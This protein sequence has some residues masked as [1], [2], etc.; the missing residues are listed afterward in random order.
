MAQTPAY[1]CTIT[2][3]GGSGST[4]G[5]IL[6][7]DTLY[8]VGGLG[9]NGTGTVFSIKTNGTG[10]KVL[11]SFAAFGTNSSGQ[12]TNSDGAYPRCKLLASG[13]TLYGTTTAGGYPYT[14]NPP[15]CGTVFKVNTDGSGFETIHYFNTNAT[16]GRIP[17]AGV[18]LQGNTLYGTTQSGGTSNCGTVFAVN[19]DGVGY[20][21]LHSFNYGDGASPEAG[22]VLSGSTLYGTTTSGSAYGTIF[23]LNTDGSGF[24]TLHSFANS[25]AV[26]GQTALALSRN[27]L[28]GANN[29]IYS[30]NTDGTGFTNLIQFGNSYPLG[31]GSYPSELTASDTAVYGALNQGGGIVSSQF[32]ASYGT[33]FTINTDG[34]GFRVMYDF[35]VFLG[36]LDS[37]GTPNQQPS[38][39]GY[40][41]LGA[42]AVSNNILYGTCSTNVF[43]M[44]FLRPDRPILSTPYARTRFFRISGPTSATIS[45]FRLDGNLVWGN[46]TPGATYT[47]QTTSAAPDN[48]NWV[49]YVEIPA[50]NSMN[51]NLIYSF[52]PPKG[53]TLIPA[54]SY[55]MGDTLDGLAT[56]AKIYLSGFYMETNLVTVGLWNSV[57]AWATNHGYSSFSA[58]SGLT[59]GAA[60]WWWSGGYG[61]AWCNARSQMEGLTPV[62]YPDAGFTGSPTSPSSTNGTYYANWSANGYRLPTDAEWEKAARGGL[63]GMRF[64]WG[65]LC[66]H[67]L[68]SYC[69]DTSQDYLFDLGPDGCASNSFTVGQYPPNGY[70][71]Y[72]MVSYL[73]QPCWSPSYAPSCQG[74]VFCAGNVAYS[75]AAYM[76]V[77]YRSFFGPKDGGGSR[78]FRCARNIGP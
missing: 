60:G 30:I 21:N 31:E 48:T 73:C 64:P 76:R 63:K 62:Y 69:S 45:E 11:H 14:F 25:G 55:T 6:S 56:P 71:L 57:T 10:F 41:P 34:T 12:Q 51:T 40:N 59:N 42:L 16:D 7:G 18:V 75:T 27:K 33:I 15:N 61:C 37:F 36:Y 38:S 46:A 67:T 65:N 19:T 66:D 43:A 24:A 77:A 28:F 39:A 50:S 32:S 35:T 5:L 1:L 4:G 8:G 49:D 78:G 29:Y 22:L 54:G 58:V 17:A 74:G 70:G 44:A 47:V 68:A 2:N 20:T 3:Y 13:N 23:S 53:M 9:S 52:H 26:W 72:D